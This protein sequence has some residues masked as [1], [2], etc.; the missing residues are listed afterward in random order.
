MQQL[1][2]LKTFT[3]H[4]REFPQLYRLD[5]KA[6]KNVTS[7]NSPYNDISIKTNKLHQRLKL[8]NLH[9]A[10]YILVQKTVIIHAV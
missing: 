4:R 8:L 6:Y 7:E 10:V 3:A 1:P 5:R 9:P 2:T